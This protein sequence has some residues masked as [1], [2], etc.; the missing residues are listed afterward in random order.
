MPIDNQE[1]AIRVRRMAQEMI[2]VAL[3]DIRKG[4]VNEKY[5]RYRKKAI[6]WFNRRDTNV[7]GYGW[8]L[9]Q[10][11]LNPNMIRRLIDKIL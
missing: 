4:K 3:R 1:F 7:F 5:L 6:V 10:S 8:C 2:I 9:Q 11:R